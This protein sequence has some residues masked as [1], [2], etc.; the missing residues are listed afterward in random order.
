MC[1]THM[2]TWAF[3]RVFCAFWGRKSKQIWVSLRT[4]ILSFFLDS[5]FVKINVL[6]IHNKIKYIKIKN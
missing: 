6:S 4:Q 1:W 3:L 2:E 5:S